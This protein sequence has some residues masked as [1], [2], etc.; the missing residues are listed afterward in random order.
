[1]QGENQVMGT[2]AERFLEYLENDM[3]PS[4]SYKMVVLKTI[5]NL[6][7]STWN[8]T[9]IA[10]GFLNYYLHHRERIVDYDD[11]ANAEDKGTFRYAELNGNSWKCR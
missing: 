4:K 1:M 8:V 9:D 6:P 3:N 5:L 2:P 11:L 7:G 10:R